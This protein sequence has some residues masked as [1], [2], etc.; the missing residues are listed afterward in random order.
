MRKLFEATERNRRPLAYNTEIRTMLEDQKFVDIQEEVIKIPLNP[1]PDDPREKDVARWYNL[2]L[3]Q[4]LEAMTLGPM[5]RMNK[6]TKDDV[7]RQITEVRRDICSRKIRA[8]NN[9]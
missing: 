8:Y 1:W 6:W 3:T 2:A 5:C 9:L 7:T 4:G